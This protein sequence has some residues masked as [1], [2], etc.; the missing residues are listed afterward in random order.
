M[1]NASE[2]PD[3]SRLRLPGYHTL[4]TIV[5]LT[6]LAAGV[7]LW[8]LDMQREKNLVWAAADVLVLLPLSWGV[9]RALRAGQFGVDII[10]LLAIVGA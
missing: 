6:F 1:P 2:S 9:L 5:V 7:V 3:R 8:L 4:L 10:A